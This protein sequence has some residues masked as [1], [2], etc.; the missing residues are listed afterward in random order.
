[1]K[2]GRD[3]G[4]CSGVAPRGVK[5]QTVLHCPGL[6]ILLQQNPADW[7]LVSAEIH[8]SQFLRLDTS[9]SRSLCASIPNGC[10][11]VASFGR[12]VCCVFSGGRQGSGFSCHPFAMVLIVLLLYSHDTIRSQRWQ[13]LMQV[14]W[15]L[16]C[17]M[18]I[19]RGTVLMLQDLS[20]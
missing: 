13:L 19:G 3:L 12:D 6:L 5:S 20:W 1:M 10:L 15:G 11:V 7:I 8:L 4:H 2:M 16:S 18:N 17:N 9:R 14:L